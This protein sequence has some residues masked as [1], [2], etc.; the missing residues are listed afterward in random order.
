M[1]LRRRMKVLK[2]LQDR[3]GCACTSRRSP[4]SPAWRRLIGPELV[5][6]ETD[7]W[8]RAT[9]RPVI[10]GS[11]AATA[12]AAMTRLAQAPRPDS[13]RPTSPGA[14][15]LAA[16]AVSR[17]PLHRVV[18]RPAGP[19]RLRSPLP[20]ARSAPR[21]PGS[22]SR[23]AQLVG[24]TDRGQQAAHERS[25]IKEVKRDGRY[26]VYALIRH[27][28]ASTCRR[29][30]RSGPVEAR[31]ATHEP[32]RPPRQRRPRLDVHLL[33]RQQPRRGPLGTPACPRGR[34]AVPASP[35]HLQ[36]AEGTRPAE[37]IHATATKGPVMGWAYGENSKAVRLAT[38]SRPSATSPAA[39]R[40]STAASTTCGDQSA[41]HH[42][43]ERTRRL[44]RLFLRR[45]PV[46]G[47]RDRVQNC[48]AATSRSPRRP[49]RVPLPLATTWTSLGAS[50][51]TGRAASRR[52]AAV[53]SP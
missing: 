44:R 3:P 12:Q 31:W 15:K 26:V 30:A 25:T 43:G 24:G 40:R 47:L 9:S 22:R 52:P 48:S 11:V 27:K 32:T 49:S 14:W 46:P 10:P 34:A 36:V 4:P 33:R 17:S 21:L 45:P 8:S 42:I 51:T 19:S 50:A 13:P 35:T 1:S 5:A 7:G 23:L 28:Q 53:T 18:N 6:L 2:V 16:L 41:G 38:E 20:K 29:G 39:P 37:V